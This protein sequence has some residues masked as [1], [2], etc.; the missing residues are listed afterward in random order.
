MNG[1]RREEHVDSWTR[2]IL[3][4]APRSIDVL[5]GAARE[6]RDDWALDFA[7]HE[8]HRLPIAARGDRET[9]FNDVDP[10]LRERLRDPQFFWLRHAAAGRLLAVAQ[11]GIEDED[12]VGVGH[13]YLDDGAAQAKFAASF[14]SPEPWYCATCG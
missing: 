10:E 12:A 14:T 8:I 11:R 4:G 2:G 9:S 13:R 1:A 3:Q 7:S 6:A 5:S